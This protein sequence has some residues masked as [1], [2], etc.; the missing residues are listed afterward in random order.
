[1]VPARPPSPGVWVGPGRRSRGL[2]GRLLESVAAPLTLAD[3]DP[4]AKAA[5]YLPEKLV[6]WARRVRVAV[7]R[8]VVSD[9]P[10]RWGS[11]SRGGIIRIN[12]RA[13]QDP[14]ALVEYILAHELVHLRHDDHSRAFWSALGRVMPDYDSRKDKLR[15][16][17]PR[18]FVDVVS[19]VDCCP[20]SE[21]AS[22]P[23]IRR[24]HLRAREWRALRRGCRADPRHQCL[25]YPWA[26]SKE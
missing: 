10:K 26:S 18:T 2:K 22:W 15:A 25:A 21:G 19:S 24:R 14:A 1:M 13:I 11:A 5:D 6:T 8:L 17:G 4:E 9:P 3:G 20:F 12:W 23:R 16:F 7:P